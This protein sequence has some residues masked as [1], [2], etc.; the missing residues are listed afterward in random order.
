MIKTCQTVAFT[1]FQF[2]NVQMPTTSFTIACHQLHTD[3]QMEYEAHEQL[4]HP[5]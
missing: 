4:Q 2:H 5:P 1:Y 3:T